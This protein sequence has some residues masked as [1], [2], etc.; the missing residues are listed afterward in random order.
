MRRSGMNELPQL[1][2][3][4]FV[5]HQALGGGVTSS[6]AIDKH[7]KCLSSFLFDMEI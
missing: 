7:G 2:A 5:L 1:G 6:A 3:F 4:I